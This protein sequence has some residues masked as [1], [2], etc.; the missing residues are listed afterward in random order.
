LRERHQLKLKDGYL[1]DYAYVKRIL[2]AFAYEAGDNNTGYRR[3][4]VI[5]SKYYFDAPI[6]HIAVTLFMPEEEV[7]FIIEVLRE[8]GLLEREDL[9]KDFEKELEEKLNEDPEDVWYR[10]QVARYG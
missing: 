1:D 4:R 8:S 3:I 6:K 5:R 9:E 7:R 10:C 2:N